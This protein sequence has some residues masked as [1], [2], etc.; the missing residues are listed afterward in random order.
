VTEA[1]YMKLTGNATCLELKVFG[2]IIIAK[3]I[4]DCYNLCFYRQYEHIDV[5]SSVFRK[6][7]C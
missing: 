5:N 2:K 6:G 4:G 3:H 1:F 7:V